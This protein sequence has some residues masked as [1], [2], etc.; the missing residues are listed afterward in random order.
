[1][2]RDGL[3]YGVDVD[4]DALRDLRRRVEREKLEN[5]KVIRGKSDDPLLPA[6]SLDAILI[7]NAYHE[8]REHEAMLRALHAA[9]KSGGRLA[10]IDAPGDDDRSRESQ[11]GSHTI[12]E[13][14]VRKEAEA[15][16]FRFRSK[17]KDFDR[18]ENSRRHWYFLVFEK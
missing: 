8:M 2:G 4:E 13:F 7:V 5:V 16:G 11:T 14:Y 3:V 17:E 1:V 18:P 12:G 9:L 15:A 6:N 10:V